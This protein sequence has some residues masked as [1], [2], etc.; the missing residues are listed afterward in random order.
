[1]RGFIQPC[2][3]AKGTRRKTPVHR[4][5]EYE[6]ITYNLIGANSAMNPAIREVAHSVHMLM[7]HEPKMTLLIS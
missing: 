1:M 7:E 3:V 2:S 5:F 6:N 4:I